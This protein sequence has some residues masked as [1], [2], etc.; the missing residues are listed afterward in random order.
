[1][2]RDVELT[3]AE[4]KVDG[5]EIFQRARQQR[6]MNREKQQEKRDAGVTHAG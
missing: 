3:D 4:R 2:V 5:V 1:M 6:Q